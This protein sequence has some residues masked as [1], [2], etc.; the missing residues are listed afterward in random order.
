MVVA[1]QRPDRGDTTLSNNASA[2]YEHLLRAWVDV[3]EGYTGGA[4]AASHL[5]ASMLAHT[6][7]S[8]AHHLS[9][10]DRQ[11]NAGA[12]RSGGDRRLGVHIT[13]RV[14]GAR[15]RPLRRGFHPQPRPAL[16]HLAASRQGGDRG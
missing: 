10:L 6:N 13:G 15:D 9:L 4:V 11:V 1:L 3:R 8:P 16:E 7:G 14:H 5:M 12:R 2:G